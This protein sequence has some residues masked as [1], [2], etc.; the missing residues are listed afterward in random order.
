MKWPFAR[1]RIPAALSAVLGPEEIVSSLAEV[2]GGGQLAVTRFGLWV[3]PATGSDNPAVRTGWEVISKARWEAG[4]L[5]LV[6]ADVMGEL[7]GAS[8][9]VD[10]VAVEYQVV[11]PR[12]T[13]DHIHTRVRGS[14][15]QATRHD[16]PGGAGWIIMRKVPGTNGLRPQVRLDS[17]TDPTRPGLAAIIADL[18]AAN[19]TQLDGD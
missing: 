11:E 1:S 2:A 8:L 19:H 12:K 3:V 15:V 6:I 4:V 5:H 7:G 16:L 17:G 14:I 10:R 9:L 13:T 18:I